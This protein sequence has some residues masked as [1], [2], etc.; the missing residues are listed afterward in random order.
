MD[1][2]RVNRGQRRPLI[3]GIIGDPRRS[4][5]QR[6]VYQGRMKRGRS[7][8]IIKWNGEVGQV[9]FESFDESLDGQLE[10]NKKMIEKLKEDE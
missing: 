10:P 3:L 4:S 2:I 7:C 6:C 5:G 1:R 9:S 8:E